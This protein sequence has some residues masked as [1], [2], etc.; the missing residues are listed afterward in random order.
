MHKVRNQIKKAALA[1]G[2]IMTLGSVLTFG[3]VRIE[4]PKLLEIQQAYHRGEIDVDRAV[5]EQ[6]RMMYEP[7]NLK[8]GQ[9]LIEKCATPAH[10][11]LHRHRN[12]LSVQTRSKV[13]EYQSEKR[14]SS[15]MLAEESYISPSGK[16]EVIYYTSGGDSVSLEDNDNNGTPDYVERVAESADSS[17][18]HEVINIGYPDPIPIGMQYR[19][20]IENVGGAYGFTA[21]SGTSPG[22]TYIVVNNNFNGFPSNSHPE[23]DTVGAI[24]ATVA[25]EFKHAIQYIQNNWSGES[26]LWL[27]MDATLME[28]VVYDDVNDYYNYID[29]FSSDLFSSASTSL[30]PGSYEDITWALFFEEYIGP[31]FWVE[32]W[33]RIEAEPSI[34]FL[35]AVRDELNARGYNFNEEMVR[36]YMWHFASGS[37]SGN[38]GY[39][40]EEKTFYPSVNVDASFG[41]VPVAGVS[42]NNINRVASRYLEITPTANDLGIIDVAIDFDSTQIGL[43]VIYY[44]KNGETREQIATGE[45]KGQVY[46]PSD[47]DWEEVN[48]VGIVTTNYSSDVSSS[49]LKLQFGTNGNPVNIK[50]PVYVDLPETIKVYQNYPNPF[51]PETTISFEIPRPAFIS[52]EVFDIMGRKVQTLVNRE[53]DVSAAR[54]EVTFNASRLSSGV[55]IYRLRIDD[56]V[57]IKKMTLVK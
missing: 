29:N 52:L 14:K 25:H 42:L 35:T 51:N 36:S 9:K 15:A 18:R 22:G 49:Q 39:G 27:E 57:F 23:G 55:Y 53:F 10:M 21:T 13:E 34:I 11:F 1:V 47:I 30:I 26:D 19:V 48:K 12:E 5:L 6:F 24:Y 16:F 54:H 38:D 44:M 4:E 17:Y 7:I 46:L 41:S 28:E 45:D 31:D 56:L 3:Q 8:D 37:R 33:E 50:D 20:Y 40:F 32:V 43:G 2:V